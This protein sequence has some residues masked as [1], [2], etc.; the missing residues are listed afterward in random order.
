[1]SNQGKIVRRSGRTRH[2]ARILG[3]SG[4]A[5]VMSGLI[6][7]A[8]AG[9]ARESLNGPITAEVVRVIDGDTIEV[10]AH[11][12]LGQ[13]LK[14]RVRLVGLD[15]PELRGR[16]EQER[17]QARQARDLLTNHLS[18]GTTVTLHD[19][20]TGKYAGRVIARMVTDQGQD[21]GAVLVKAGLARPYDGGAR[22]S[23]CGV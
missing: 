10:L 12:W 7:P 5:V 6:A 21:I 17:V 13:N 20:A 22:A 19:V 23:W 1:M 9:M 8:T 2:G 16:C 18:A 15:T 4:L 11:I 3:V 14:T